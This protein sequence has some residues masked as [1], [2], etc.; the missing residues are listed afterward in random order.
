MLAAIVAVTAVAFARVHSFDFVAWDDNENITENYLYQPSPS[1]HLFELWTVPYYAAYIPI[2]RLVWA[3]LV[4]PGTGGGAATFDPHPFHVVN[5]VLHAVNA[6][7]AFLILRFFVRK[8]WAAALGALVFALHPLQV[9]PVSWVTGLKDVLSGFFSLLAAWLY[10]CYIHALRNGP[11][12]DPSAH[13]R[14]MLMIAAATVSYALGLLSKSSTV[15]LPLILVWLDYLLG[16]SS[17]NVEDGAK[18]APAVPLSRLGLM[19]GWVLAAIP[20]ILLTKQAE[21][22]AGIRI[23]MVHIW[24]RP[25]VAGDTLAFYLGKSVAPVNLGPDY[26]RTPTWLMHHGWAYAMVAV[27]VVLL[28]AAWAVRKRAIWP[29][30]SLGI[31][32]LA[33]LPVTGITPFDFQ[34]ISTVADRYM[35]VAM[36]GV[37]LAFASVVSMLPEKPAW[38]VGVLLICALAFLTERQIP[39][40]RSTHSLFS[41]GMKVNPNSPVCWMSL[42]RVLDDQGHLDEAI[43]YY[44]KAVALNPASEQAHNNLGQGLAK[45]W[46]A[47]ENAPG[48]QAM[49]TEARQN[50]ETSI[51]LRDN[52][53]E[54]HSNLGNVYY[55]LGRY[56]DAITQFQDVLHWDKA[57]VQ[58]TYMLGMLY[59]K[60]GDSSNSLTYLKKAADMGS[61]QA[62]QALGTATR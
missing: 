14:R 60:A 26:G 42:G 40:W 52:F 44:R 11:P 48:A 15:T 8:D 45:K 50:L 6:G 2:T 58:A 5:L 13:N 37:A 53:P 33:L 34:A 25:F 35:Y 19:L 1:V 24:Q 3:A 22:A 61:A 7:L 51:H 59:G 31:F 27:P 56:Q 32:V 17:A 16:E 54:G 55:G 47:N 39:A 38:V 23:P 9:E 29:L 4:T 36:L 41:Q 62:Q 21:D 18:Q 49:I 28:A 12:K 30:A 10:L 43:A 20:I 46:F 57:N